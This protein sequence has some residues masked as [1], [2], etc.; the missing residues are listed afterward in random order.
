[1]F[2]YV[3]LGLLVL[4][5]LIL[6][7]NIVRGL[8]KGLKKSL[9]C[10]V[11][12]VLSV[13]IAL[14]LTVTI[15]TP[16]NVSGLS[17]SLQP[18]LNESGAEEIL[19]VEELLEAI[20]S[21]SIMLVA[22]FFFTLVFIV[23][24][25]IVCL[26]FA[27]VIRFIPILNGFKGAKNR[28]LGVLVGFV[29][30][31][32]VAVI[33]L[34]PIVGTLDLVTSADGVL[35]TD[36]ED[37]ELG[38]ILHDAAEDKAL[39]FLAATGMRPVYNA[40]AST[41][42]E[43]EKVYLK[44][45]IASF[46]TIIDNIDVI[47]GDFSTYGENEIASMGKMVDGVDASPLIKST[48]AGILST[49]AEKWIANESFFGVESPNASGEDNPTVDTMLEI[50][51]TSDKNTIVPDLRTVTDVLAILIRNGILSNA[52][53]EDILDKIGNGSVIS[54]I[55]V[56]VIN[57][58]RMSPL[59]DV[60]VQIGVNAIASAAGIPESSDEAGIV[61]VDEICSE[62]GKYTDTA[63]AKKEAEKVANI[64]TT[65]IESFKEIDFGSSAPADILTELGEILDLMNESEIFGQRFTSK[66]LV[67][68]MQSDN[69][70]GSLGISVAESTD[71]ANKINDMVEN[72][73]FDYT[74]ATE[75]IADTIT[76]IEATKNADATKE[77][78]KENV[79]KL[80]DNLTA[81]S[82]E[83]I[84]TMVTSSLVESYG[85]SS[86]KSDI[87][88]GAVSSLLDNMA[89]YETTEENSEESAKEA[90]AVST[91]LDLAITGSSTQGSLFTTEEGG[92]SLET[93]ADEFVELVVTSSVV[94]TTIDKM[95]HE[96]GHNDNPLGIPELSESDKTEITGAIES[97]YVNNGGGADLAKTLESIAAMMNVNVELDKSGN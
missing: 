61:T 77:E 30:G 27:I 84:G 9:A 60:I 12:I 83:M 52:E 28:L 10:L 23:V 21:Y 40:F 34:M 11:A 97:Y 20:S 14:I 68:L 56:A 8:V 59:A 37:N 82:A 44:N 22:P 3:S 78:K 86:E 15:C 47:T 19:E 90:E 31:F 5:S 92:G 63:D 93:S 18:M 13:L 2:Q 72:G 69:V 54:D 4:F 29:C 67:A 16:S 88:S 51:A 43:G 1:M 65:A 53:G 49:A 25:L 58:D 71:F 24:S 81:E 55:T 57:N 96:D 80:L 39:D 41:R 64:I 50:L 87:V 62:L 7:L 33:C 46:V 42:F 89:S 70:T 36:A 6:V 66:L 35:S 48:A 32:I 38:E 26:I 74:H 95:V 75:V 91:L 73:H 85:V 76:M 94:S 79:Q 17:E 45:E